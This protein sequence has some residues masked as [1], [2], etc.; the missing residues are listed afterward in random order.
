MDIQIEAARWLVLSPAAAVAAIE[1]AAATLP[2]GTCARA[3][4]VAKTVEYTC[5]AA[6]AEL[7]GRV[8]ADLEPDPKCTCGTPTAL[9][10]GAAPWNGEPAE[11][12]VVVPDNT[13]TATQLCYGPCEEV[14]YSL[15]VAA[16]VVFV[17]GAAA[18]VID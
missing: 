5:L 12:C 15:A 18:R 10:V 1:P 13:T 6:L 17:A 4:L 14:G 8:A 16:G 3:D 7:Y 11:R 2:A 9:C